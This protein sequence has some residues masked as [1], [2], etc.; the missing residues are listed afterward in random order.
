MSLVTNRG[1]TLF[2]TVIS[3]AILVLIVSLSFSYMSSFSH[4]RVRAE[5]DKLA[6]ICV[7]LHKSA[8]ASNR[9]QQ[10]VFDRACNAY[11]YNGQRVQLPPGVRFAAASHIAG[12]PSAPTYKIVSPITF[13]KD[14]IVFSPEGNI[15]AGTVYLS[16]RRCQCQYALT[17]SV[18]GSSHIRRYRFSKTWTLVS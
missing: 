1:M 5:L 12:P 14:C 6:H 10:L 17:V 4:Q 7:F 16:D 13:E 18:D 3:C 11:E 15:R 8:L 9:T 2:E